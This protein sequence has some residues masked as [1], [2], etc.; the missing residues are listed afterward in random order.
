MFVSSFAI[1]LVAGNL[2]GKHARGLLISPY[3]ADRQLIQLSTL[4]VL[5]GI[6]CI[7]PMIVQNI[8]LCNTP[9]IC[10]FVAQ[11][12]AALFLRISTIFAAVR[13]SPWMES[14]CPYTDI[15]VLFQACLCLKR[16]C[17]HFRVLQHTFT[18]KTIQ[19]L[20]KRVKISQRCSQI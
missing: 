3:H 7:W 13:H 4:L 14:L 20:L 9:P 18:I 19:K 8:F 2:L 11:R 6:C 5:V 10:F 17:Y 12:Q 1:C 16:P 15:S